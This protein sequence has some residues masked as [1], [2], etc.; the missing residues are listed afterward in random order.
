MKMDESMPG[1]NAPI[2]YAHN[3]F[4]FVTAGKLKA[5]DDGFD[6]FNVR[7]ELMKSRTN[8]AGQFANLI[9]NQEIGFDPILTQYA[10]ANDNGIVEG[11]N[12]YRYISN[13]KDIK[14]DSRKFRKEFMDN[15]ALRYALYDQTVPILRQQLSRVDPTETAS[16]IHHLEVLARMM[17]SQ[18]R[19]GEF[20]SIA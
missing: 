7:C 10:F 16:S 4:K 15:E 14:F 18:E 2:Y 1:G 13:N 8:K 17:V 9:Y 12:P 20:E 6:G 3:L 5:E 11:R 19:D